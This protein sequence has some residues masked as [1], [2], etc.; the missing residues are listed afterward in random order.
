[1]FWWALYALLVITNAFD[2]VMTYHAVTS[3]VAEEANPLMNYVIQNWGW[4]W[5]FTV[6]FFIVIPLAFLVPNIATSGKILLTLAVSAYLALTGWHLFFN[7]I[8]LE[9]S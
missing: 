5:F 6:K 7:L 3:G 4:V 9:A 8:L 2:A 1:M